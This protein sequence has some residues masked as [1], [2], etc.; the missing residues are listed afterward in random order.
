MGNKRKQARPAARQ[1]VKPKPRIHGYEI[2]T[3]IVNEQQLHEV[4]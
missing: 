1:A 3:I 4:K 2:D